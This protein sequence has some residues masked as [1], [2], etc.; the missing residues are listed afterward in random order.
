MA[1]IKVG[2]TD[3]P[4]P[5]EMSFGIQD[6]KKAERNARGNLI[7]E[8]ITTKRKLELS[9]SFLTAA[10]LQTILTAVAPNAFS[11]TYTDPITNA[12]RTGTFYAGDRNVGVI[13]FMNGVPR[14]KDCR[15]SLVEV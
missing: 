6:I 1:I 2:S 5:S 10:Q 12:S 15:F 4:S 8:L 11:V 9:W 14:Y 13:D 7:S 3:L